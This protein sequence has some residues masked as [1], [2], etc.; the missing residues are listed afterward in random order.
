MPKHVS[1]RFTRRDLW[2]AAG[3]A[4]TQAW[5]RLYAGDAEF[6]NKKDPSE[7]TVAEM[8]KLKTKSPWAKQMTVSAQASGTGY[9]GGGGMGDPGIGGGRG[10]GYPGMGGGMGRGRGRA[11]GMPMQYQ[12]VVRWMSAKPLQAIYKKPLPESMADDY[13]ISVSGIPLGSGRGRQYGDEDRTDSNDSRA[14]ALER[15]KGLTYL[16]P[17][18]KGPAQPGVVEAS[19]DPSADPNT[20]LFGFS[21]ELLPLSAEDREVTF[22]TQIGRVEVKAKFNLKEMRY[23]D[24]LAV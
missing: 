23:K 15:I 4:G 20:L 17:K 18:G 7:W 13:V 8:D 12:T 16:E 10:M 2:M 14:D 22:T 9:G 6:W 21:R 19:K 3:A 11:R 5:F 24:E 1:L